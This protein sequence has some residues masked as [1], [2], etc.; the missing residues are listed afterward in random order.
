MYKILKEYRYYIII[1]LILITLFLLIFVFKTYEFYKNTNNTK[2]FIHTECNYIQ[3]D[4]LMDIIKETKERF[5]YN[6]YLPCLYEDNSEEYDKFVK[7]KNGIYFLIDNTDIM[8]GKD[9]L[10]K[11]VFNTYG[12]EKTIT[13]MPES[14]IR[15][16][17]CDKCFSVPPISNP[18]TIYKIETGL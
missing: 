13:L 10:Y 1:T 16:M 18:P 17:I 14:L 5:N 3:S 7:D 2:Y 12:R 8:V 11:N 4:T 15:G 6:L 9:Y